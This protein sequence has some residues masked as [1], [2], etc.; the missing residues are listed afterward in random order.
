MRAALYARVSTDRQTCETQSLQLYELAKL[1]NWTVIEAFYDEGISGAK[2]RQQRPGLDRLLT[3]AKE[4]KFDVVMVWA[5]DRLGRST[6]DLVT[7]AD[8]LKEYRVNLY[9]HQNNIDTTTPYGQFF[10]DMMA[11]LAQLERE[12]IRSRVK[13]GLSRVKASGK[14]LGRKFVEEYDPELHGRV[15]NLLK[16]GCSVWKVHLMTG[17]GVSMVQRLNRQINKETGNVLA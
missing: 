3:A 5:L 7:I 16:D 8:D 6:R 12:V 4:K 17:A 11:A 10:Y 14:K 2:G 9:I 13:A 1:K 15:I